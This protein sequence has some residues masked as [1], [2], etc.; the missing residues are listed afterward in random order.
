MIIRNRSD[1]VIVLKI[2]FERRIVSF[3]ANNIKWTEFWWS[4]EHLANIFVVKLKKIKLKKYFPLFF[5]IFIPSLRYL[6]V[7]RIRKTI[8][9]NGAQ[10][11][12]RKMMSKYFS[13]PS[14]NASFFLINI[15]R[16]SNASGDNTNLSWPYS[17]P[18]T[19]SFNIEYT[20]VWN[21]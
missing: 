6:K 8:C 11:R 16:E 5:D 21:N 20:W 7:S 17:Q 15:N 4:F 14:S 18:P 12:K 1:R 19:K 10:L 3:P 9:T 13:Y 2:I